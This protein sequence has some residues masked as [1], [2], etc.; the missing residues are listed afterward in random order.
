MKQLREKLE[1]LSTQL[2]EEKRA[3]DQAFKEVYSSQVQRLYEICSAVY[4]DISGYYD[5]LQIDVEAF[6]QLL[7]KLDSQ[8]IW[9]REIETQNATARPQTTK[10]TQPTSVKQ[11]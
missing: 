1:G 7:G 6:K 5:R 10:K 2:S 9:K 11:L 8:S 4:M 3:L